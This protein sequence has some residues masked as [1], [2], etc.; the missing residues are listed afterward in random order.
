M[1]ALI[2]DGHVAAAHD[3]SDGGWLVAAAEMCIAS[4]HGLNIDPQLLD[5]ADFFAESPGRYLIELNADAVRGQIASALAKMFSPF[6]SVT[7]L[8]FVQHRPSLLIMSG[9][10]IVEDLSIPDLTAA[11]RGTLDW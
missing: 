3:V 8:G 9:K 2:A 4:G 11:W 7:Q 1:S 5:S 6:A 10:Q